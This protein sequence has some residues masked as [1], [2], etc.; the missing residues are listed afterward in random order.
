ML[1]L[2]TTADLRVMAIKGYP[3]SPKLQNFWSLTIRLFRVITGDS[4]GYSYRS[5]E[6]QSVYSAAPANWAIRYDLI[7]CVCC[8]LA[9]VRQPI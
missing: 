6:K 1:P 5:A 9:L 8:F 7:I 3:H 2:R 4:L